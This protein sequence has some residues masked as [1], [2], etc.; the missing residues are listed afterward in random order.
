[1]TNSMTSL[2]KLLTFSGK[3]KDWRIWSRRFLALSTEKGFNKILDGTENIPSDTEVLD[4]TSNDTDIKT[5]IKARTANRKAYSY[6]MMT[7]TESASFNA[8]DEAR[9]N[10]HPNGNARQAWTNLNELYEPKDQTTEIELMTEFAAMTLGENQKPSEFFSKIQYIKQRMK[11]VKHDL[12][13]SQIIAQT[14]STLLDVYSDYKAVLTS[15]LKDTMKPLTLK[16]LKALLMSAYKEKYPTNTNTKSSDG[17]AFI[18]TGNNYDSSR[19]SGK[20]S[21]GYKG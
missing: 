9:T 1:M 8:I 6:L 4:T 15:R 7:C 21:K 11:T 13:E 17:T 2:L 5:K 14:I 18:A 3:D 20:Y 16:E 19:P 12:K 10:D